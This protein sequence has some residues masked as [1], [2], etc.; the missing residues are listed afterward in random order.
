MTTQAACTGTWHG[1]WTSC[2]PNNCPQPTGA[3]C[4]HGFCTIETE[5]E[6]LANQ[7]HFLGVGT[8]CTPPPCICLG[9]S[10][11]DGTV[12]WRDIDFFVAAIGSQAAWENMFAPGT[13]SCSYLSNDV[14]SDGVVNWRDID[15]LVVLMGTVCP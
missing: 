11:C 4:A 6:C 7:G 2:S 5:A 1:E 9:D 10:N 12:N 15:P 14:D 8:T 3:C 13:P